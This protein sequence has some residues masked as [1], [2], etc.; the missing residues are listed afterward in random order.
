MAALFSGPAEFRHTSHRRQND[1]D[2]AYQEYDVC[3]RQM[4]LEAFKPQTS[5]PG[6]AQFPVAARMSY[7]I[8]AERY[9][10]QPLPASY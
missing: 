6:R 5:Q 7:H 8:H 10:A 3:K 1:C 4:A 2:G 9:T